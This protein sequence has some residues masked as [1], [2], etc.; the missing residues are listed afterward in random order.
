METPLGVLLFW[1]ITFGALIG[2]A[3]YFI[4]GREGVSLIPSTLMGTAGAVIVGLITYFLDF[5]LPL[6]YA[7]LGAVAFLFVTNVF[8]QKD[9]PVFKEKDYA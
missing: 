6:A 2:Y 3:G 7:M 5:S 1:M 8:R 9:K 4:Y